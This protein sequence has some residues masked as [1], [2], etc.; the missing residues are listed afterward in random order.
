M[1]CTLL[2]TQYSLE[3]L[4]WKENKSI[5]I[6]ITWLH[7]AYQQTYKTFNVLQCVCHSDCFQN[8]LLLRRFNEPF[9]SFASSSP[10]FI[11]F[12]FHFSL[13]CVQ[14]RDESA[15]LLWKHFVFACKE[16][17]WYA[18]GCS[19]FTFQCYIMRFWMVNWFEWIFLNKFSILMRRKV[20]NHFGRCLRIDNNRNIINYNYG[21]FVFSQL[22]I[23]ICN[24]YI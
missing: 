16:Y 18:G 11:W 1:S 5:K 10:S 2:H 14:N 24:N 4:K 3:I 17:E 9:S 6:L 22:L 23:I 21:T 15:P 12:I 13:N 8:Y 7:T 19:P 20:M